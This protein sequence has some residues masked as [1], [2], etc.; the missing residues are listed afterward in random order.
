MKKTYAII[1]AML[2]LL[3]PF[4][5]APTEDTVQANVVVNAF[6]SISLTDH[7]ATGLNFGGVDPATTGTPDIDQNILTG[8]VTV[9]NEITSNSN[10]DIATKGN[11]F[12]SSGGIDWFAVENL[13]YYSDTNAAAAIPLT[14][15]Y[16]N[17]YNEVA[18][19]NSVDFWFFLDVP[20]T[21]QADTYSS[22]VSFRGN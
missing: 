10:I 14:N 5:V 2:V 15:D 8:A 13:G 9:T 17:F 12:N 4:A 11:D 22:T 19:N 21:Q 3:S 16:I 20:P 6:I 1:V 18:P 7:G